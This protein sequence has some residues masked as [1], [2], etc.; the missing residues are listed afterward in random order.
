MQN[1]TIEESKDYKESD[2]A[3]EKDASRPILDERIGRF[4]FRLAEITKEH[5][6]RSFART[7]GVS[8][9]T[10]RSYLRG[11]TYP[12]LPALDGIAQAAEVNTV[13]LATGEGP[14]LRSEKRE[15]PSYDLAE[16]T[17]VPRYP[18][19]AA[20]GAGK[21]VERESEIGKLAFRRDW[22]RQKGLSTNDLSVIRIVGDS[23]SPT[24]R[25]GALA[26]VD[27]RRQQEKPKSDGIYVI[28]MD[29]DLIA[30]RIQIDLAS[31]GLYIRSDNPLY[32]EQ[33][34]TAEQAEYLTIIGRVIWA[35]G[36]L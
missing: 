18:V 14:M 22:L 10:L 32:K 4:K 9:G 13:W 26:L 12:D 36:E 23:M 6:L 16:F 5:S 33:H 24:I 31:G 35:G 25:D 7:C 29:G 34:V 30:K 11:D 27:C 28:Q 1:D 21:A 17:M 8:E 15:T 19:D 3:T 20:A 2:A